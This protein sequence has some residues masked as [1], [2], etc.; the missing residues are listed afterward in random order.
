MQQ[1]SSCSDFLILLH[2]SHCKF[3]SD[4]VV[5]V[6]IFDRAYVLPTELATASLREPTVAWSVFWSYVT[7]VITTFAVPQLT[8]ATAADLGAKTAFVFAGCQL[9]TIIWS[10][11][12]IPETRAR[13]IAEIDEM[14][15]LK[16]PMRAWRNHKCSIVTATACQ[17]EQKK[18]DGDHRF[19]G[20]D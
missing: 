13:T 1:C 18:G 6:L 14:Y 19:S 5:Q 7:A 12:Y 8:N 2:F 15:S 10:Y 17:V 11:F 4:S 3:R 20:V 9:I 16:L